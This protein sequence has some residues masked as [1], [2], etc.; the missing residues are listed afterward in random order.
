MGGFSVGAANRARE[1][2]AKSRAVYPG[3]WR[4]AVGGHELGICH[5]EVLCFDVIFHTKFTT[6]RRGIPR[7]DRP[8]CPKPLQFP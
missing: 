4:K 6:F 5:T 3:L 7:G 1:E 2:L 8:S